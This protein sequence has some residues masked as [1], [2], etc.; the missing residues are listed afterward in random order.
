MPLGVASP[1]TSLGGVGGE[2]RGAAPLGVARRPRQE[3]SI[4]DKF[5]R[6]GGGRGSFARATLSLSS[7]SQNNKMGRKVVFERKDEDGDDIDYDSSHVY[8]HLLPCDE[9]KVTELEINQASPLAMVVLPFRDIET[10]SVHGAGRY[11]IADVLLLSTAIRDLKHLHLSCMVGLGMESCHYLSAA[12]HPDRLET[13]E[14]SS[15]EL[16]VRRIS[17]WIRAM[18]RFTK[19]RSFSYSEDHT[20][21]FPVPLFCQ[22]II[23]PLTTLTL[24][25]CG[26]QDSDLP[27]LAER[28]PTLTSL[29]IGERVTTIDT[30]LFP[31]LRKLYCDQNLNLVQITG[32]NLSRLT[33]I[34]APSLAVIENL[35]ACCALESI[36]VESV[37]GVPERLDVLLD[38]CRRLTHLRVWPTYTDFVTEERL[39]RVLRHPSIEHV[40]IG[41]NI[42]FRILVEGMVAARR[43]ARR[44]VSVLVKH[45]SLPLEIYRVLYRMLIHTS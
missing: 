34:R 40:C 18:A 36:S 44:G 20:A 19:L 45:G 2:G 5:V 30:D 26:V 8:E 11:T 37:E 4:C 17:I 6:R 1:P 24:T 21:N 31:A 28:Y 43:R 3:L 39:Q 42:E 29:R 25:R 16:D 32:K 10:L 33:D 14:L 38:S 9:G 15:C 41:E 35:P 7:P 27:L 12:L 13:L 22:N 23:A